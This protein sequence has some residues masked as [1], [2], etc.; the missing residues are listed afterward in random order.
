MGFYVSRVSIMIVIIF[1]LGAYTNSCSEGDECFNKGIFVKTCPNYGR[2]CKISRE[3]VWRVSLLN[4][5][6][7]RLYIY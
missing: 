5:V 7:L 3:H 4:F 2:S 6:Y 1:I